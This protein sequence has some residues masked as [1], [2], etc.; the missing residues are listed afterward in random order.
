MACPAR[1]GCSGACGSAT[2]TSSCSTTAGIARPT[3]CATPR[4][5]RC[6]ARPSS[7]GCAA[8]SC[9]RRAPIKLVVNGSQL[10]NRG[11]R[12]EGWTHFT[13][14]QQEF[15]RW[16][17]DQKIDGVLFASGDRHFSELL[18][19]PREGAYPLYEFTSSPLTSRPFDIKDAAERDNPDVV[20]GTYSARRQFGLIRVTGPS[21]ARHLTLET[22]DQA[23][24]LVWRQEIDARDL[25]YRR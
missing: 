19:V 2:S 5:R 6:S 23:G 25:R 17:D 16:L 9:I 12:F 7:N 3:R 20:P 11:N 8:R 4:A 1:P 15:L 10:Y 21:D 24:A 22:H 13:A 14:E 18:R